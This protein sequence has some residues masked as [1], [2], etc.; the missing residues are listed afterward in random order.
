MPS[1]SGQYDYNKLRNLRNLKDMP[2]EEYDEWYARKVTGIAIDKVF[3]KRIQ[4]KIDEFGKDYDLSDLKAND[5]MMLRALAQKLIFLDDLE[6]ASYLIRVGGL[7]SVDDHTE[8]VNLGKISELKNLNDTASA[9]T[10]DIISL[11]EN[12]NISRKSRKNDKESSVISELERLKK[13]ASEFYEQRMFYIFCPKC[14]ELLATAW[15]L[16]PEESRNKIRLR[17]NRKPDGETIC[18]GTLLIGSKE[19]LEKRGINIQ[20]VPDYFK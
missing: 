20:E 9:I 1:R 17:C 7:V 11:Q 4:D 8:S 16:Y 14:K 6:Q 18:G 2:Q 3:E 10:K 12:L 15:F 19:L 5:M 13:A